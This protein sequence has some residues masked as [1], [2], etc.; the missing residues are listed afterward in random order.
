MR[1][2]RVEVVIASKLFHL[3]ELHQLLTVQYG[4]CWHHAPHVGSGAAA[5][6][7]F[8]RRLIFVFLLHASRQAPDIEELEAAKK[9]IKEA[10]AAEIAAIRGALAERTAH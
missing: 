5:C 10:A 3:T 9:S 6:L 8:D 4:L 7:R 1:L 2:I